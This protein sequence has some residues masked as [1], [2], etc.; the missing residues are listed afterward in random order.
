MSETLKIVIV[1]CPDEGSSQKLAR[2]IVAARL[3]ACVN[4]IPGIRSIYSWKDKIED[5]QEHI[6]VIKTGEERLRE[7][8]ETLIEMHPYDTPE[9][10]VLDTE[11]VNEKYLSWVLG[12]TV[13]KDQAGG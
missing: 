6:L 11:H 8:E 13:Q 12:Q 10:V 5:E 3:A 9:F 4:I 7:L 2:A 1:T